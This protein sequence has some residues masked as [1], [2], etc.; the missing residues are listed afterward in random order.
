MFELTSDAAEQPP[1]CNIHVGNQ[2]YKRRRS[3]PLSL[4]S[5]QSF[6]FEDVHTEC[7]NN[8]QALFRVGDC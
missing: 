7:C 3:L 6:T 4:P 8:D 1:S 5:P 2:P